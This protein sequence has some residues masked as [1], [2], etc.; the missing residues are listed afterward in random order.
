M[1]MP[2][3]SSAD[4]ALHAAR[5]LLFALQNP[6]PASP[7]APVT[8]KQSA[9]L[10]QL[11]DIFTTRTE[12]KNMDNMTSA[13]PRVGPESNRHP[14]NNEKTYKDTMNKTKQ[15]K[16]NE[17]Q[18]K[19][20]EKL[21]GPKSANHNRYA[22]LQ[23]QPDG[24]LKPTSYSHRPHSYNTRNNAAYHKA[25]ANNTIHTK[26]LPNQQ[27]HQQ[28]FINAVI[29]PTTGASQEYRHLIKGPDAERWIK[30]NINEIGR[31]TDGRVGDNVVGTNTIRF[32][33]PTE[34]PLG[35]IPTY[36]RVVSD[37][38]PQKADPYRIRWTVG[39]NLI[40]Y[41][42]ITT[43]PGAEMT[44]MK[45]LLNSV[46]STPQARFMCSDIKDFYLNTPMERYEYMWIPI[47]MLP[48]TIVHAYDLQNLITNGRVLVEISKGMYGLPQAG[49]LA[50]D[51]LVAN[52]APH[53]YHPVARTPGLWQHT[54]RPI[55]FCLVVDD[56]GVK[57]VGKG[58]AEHLTQ[59]IRKITK[60]QR[61]GKA[62]CTAEYPLHGT[63]RTTRSTY[64]CPTT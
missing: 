29:D 36:L 7:I 17:K 40:N 64:P 55:A 2:A 41:P 8:D 54:T 3:T 48:P 4:A 38:R 53:G 33:K 15:R 32:I 6:H 43:T 39:G 20:K 57:Y 14:P 62:S 16:I 35:R 24:L 28:Q 21:A 13:A 63:T 51:N 18:P 12:N 37:Y 56:F 23:D 44:T 31:L 47:S 1:K 50:Y 49:R 59:A 46:V 11:A 30:A 34:L 42:G 58:H 5:D 25:H 22:P 9:A 27:T 52:L 10:K 26:K 61:I 45:I 60:Q 19:E